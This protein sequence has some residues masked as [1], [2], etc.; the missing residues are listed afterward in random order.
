MDTW[1]RNLSL[2]V[3]HCDGSPVASSSSAAAT[4]SQSE[5]RCIHC[6]QIF[7]KKYKLNKH[8]KKHDPEFQCDICDKR[9]EYKKDLLRHCCEKHPDTFPSPIWYCAEQGCKYS[10]DHGRGFRRKDHLIRHI[11]S[12][13]DKER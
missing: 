4:S 10:K 3:H 2:V 13:H 1:R 7:D 9:F 6:G 11:R 12:Q 8:H 5:F